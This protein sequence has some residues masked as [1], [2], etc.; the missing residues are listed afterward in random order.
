MIENN[1]LLKTDSYKFSHYLQFPPGSQ[2][3]HSYLES[4]GGTISDET[5]F[6]GLQYYLKK[7]LE[8]CVVTKEMVDEA[9]DLVAAHMGPGLFNRT[10]WM[11]IVDKHKGRLPVEIRAIPEGTRVNVSNALVTIINTDPRCY[12]LP[13][14][15]ETLL[16]KVWY[17]ITVATLSRKIKE[18]IFS[19]LE[20]TGDPSTIDFKL[21]DFGYRGVSSE[22]S[23]ALGGASHLLNFKGTDTIAGILMLRKYY[24][25]E[26][27]P[28]FSIPA[29]E[30][31]TITSWG[32]EHEVDAFENMLIKY[33]DGLVAVVSD[34]Y[35]IFKACS[36]LWGTKLKKQIENRNGTLV[37]RPDSGDP[38]STVLKVLHIL[39]DKFGCECNS[40]GYKVLPRF[41]R[42]LQGDGVNYHSIR[43][44]LRCME[45]HSFSAD[46]IGFGMGGA[47]LQT[48]NRDTFKFAFKASAIMID[49][50][51]RDVYKHPVTDV[52]KE[53]KRGLLALSYLGE[54]Q[55]VTV[56]KDPNE[57]YFSDRLTPVFRDGILLKNYK[58][59]EVLENVNRRDYGMSI[60]M[61]ALKEMD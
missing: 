35:D 57:N 15:L 60:K 17:P 48:L 32:E 6:F 31:S 54:S 28:G 27:M 36:D 59:T 26:E 10:D 45:S 8:G 50:T 29:S 34:S 49:G 22:E 61:G 4:R 42:V 58:F 14:Y 38:A 40:K 9:S 2:Y 47:L 1:I 5:I 39:E 51:W 41:I 55:F 30:H 23:A 16:L 3:V 21:Q 52:G 20:R 56:R 44:I 25:A 43:E 13:N 24:D 18:L 11:Y 53:S 7:Y 37:I 46:N 19:F 33:P 12:W